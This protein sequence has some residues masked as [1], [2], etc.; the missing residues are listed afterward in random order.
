MKTVFSSNSELAHVWANQLQSE[1]RT[2]NMFFEGP[3]IYSYGT[4][5]EIARFVTAPNG[6]RVCFV[7]SNYYSS[8]TAKHT[9]H[10][11]N[12]IPDGILVFKVPFIKSTGSYWGMQKHYFDINELSKVIESMLIHCRNL[13][14][15]QLKAV[16]N[17]FYFLD[18]NEKFDEIKEICTLFGLDIPAKPENWDKAKEK[19][20]YLRSTQGEREKAK[21]L[22]KLEK[23][24][25]LLNRWLNNEYHGQLYGIPV[26][27]RVSKD[28]TQ[29][30]TTKGAK[31]ET[32][33]ALVLLEKLQKFDAV[34]ENINGFTV[35][36]NTLDYVKIGCHVIAWPVINQVFNTKALN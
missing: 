16:S 5:Y 1:G 25:E 4:H 14:Y 34:G 28:G 26:H 32:A 24:K 31:V 21:D 20:D 27:L 11:W 2:G 13:V 6:Q 9:N 19:A 30:E 10:A 7:N 8:S 15:D 33:K 35:I 22:K 18:A 23:E 29:I 3:V 12:A 17:F 36:E